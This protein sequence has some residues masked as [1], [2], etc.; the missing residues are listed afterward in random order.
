[1]KGEG[2][3]VEQTSTEFVLWGWGWKWE[4]GVEGEGG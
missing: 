4:E 3:I 1:M 2:G